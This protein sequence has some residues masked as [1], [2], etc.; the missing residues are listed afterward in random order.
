MHFPMWR[1]WA[2]LISVVPSLRYRWTKWMCPELGQWCTPVMDKGVHHSEVWCSLWCTTV[3]SQSASRDSGL[4][5]TQGNN[6][7]Y[8]QRTKWHI[9]NA[10]GLVNKRFWNSDFW[11]IWTNQEIA[12]ICVN[13]TIKLLSCL[14]IWH[15]PYIMHMSLWRYT[16]FKAIL[17][18]GWRNL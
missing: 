17:G 6:V 1:Y 4:T 3:M 9:I 14:I 16:A 13:V 5:S 10:V 11:L 2:P 7:R 8:F 15:K 12:L 18:T